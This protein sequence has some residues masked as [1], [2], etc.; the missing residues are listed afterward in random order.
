[1]QPERY[2]AQGARHD[3]RFRAP[4]M[5]RRPVRRKLAGPVGGGNIWRSARAPPLIGGTNEG[6]GSGP[7]S[8]AIEASRLCGAWRLES[9]RRIAA[10]G[11]ETTPYTT[12]P[13]GRIIYEPGGRMAA[14]MMHP[15]WPAA[16]VERGNAAYSG[17]FHVRD[18]AVHHLVDFASS[19]AMLGK[20]LVRQATL[21]GDLLTL[22]CPAIDDPAAREVLEW[23]R[24]PGD[25]P[26]APDAAAR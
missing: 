17:R 9:W 20:D 21:T 6:M 16:D 4:G 22:E 18:G 2:P 12:R 26:P 25:E 14:F 19:R 23:R 24:T 5:P 13:L 1:M 10:D 8:Q 15:D 11:S 3:Y 7:V